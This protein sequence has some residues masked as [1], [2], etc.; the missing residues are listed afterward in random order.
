MRFASPWFLLLFIVLFAVYYFRK[1]KKKYTTIK[2]S[3]ISH[4][5]HLENSSTKFLVRC[6][7]VLRFIILCLIILA[8]A[9]PQSVSTEQDVL[10][11][12]IDIMFVMDT[13]GSMLAEDFVP[14]NRISVSKSTAIDFVN[15]RQF[16]RIG[17][18]VFGSDA[19]TQCPLTLDYLVLKK[20]INDVQTGM[21][22]QGTSIG[23]AIATALNRFSYSV[24][25][26]KLLI[27]V[28]DGENNSGQ[29][30]PITASQLAKDLGVK[31]YT[32]GVGKK[33][34]API[35]YFD[36]VYGKQYR[37]LPN[38]TLLMPKLDEA[39]LRKIANETGGL[40]FRA[41]NKKS[42]EQI[43]SD[44]DKYEKTVIKTKKYFN[45]KDLFSLLLWIAFTLFV[46]ELVVANV[47][48]VRIP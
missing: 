12:G 5:V 18:V 46:I 47:I 31:I 27:L 4:L 21:A 24:S 48:L 30:D 33:G 23:L 19:Y 41:T 43:Y 32:I 34:G 14:K 20:F 22:G 9:R 7:P 42:L 1:S 26:T 8:L 15:K 3:Q 39:L 35:P 2:Y 36:D 40:Y 17:L 37:R 45:Y 29:I 28:T 25:K 16:D 10:S 11:E 38:G 6:V 13:S 44:I